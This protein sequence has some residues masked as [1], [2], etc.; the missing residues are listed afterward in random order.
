MKTLIGLIIMLLLGNAQAQLIFRNHFGP[1]D[2]L[3][4]FPENNGVFSPVSAKEVGRD[5][6]VYEV[7]LKEI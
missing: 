1:L 7:F 5:G 4:L 2:I 3:P 6:A